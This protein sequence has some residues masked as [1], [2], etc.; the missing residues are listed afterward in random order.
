MC[1]QRAEALRSAKRARLGAHGELGGGGMEG[2]DAEEGEE[3]PDEA[4][5][6][7]TTVPVRPDVRT[8]HPYMYFPCVCLEGHLCMHMQRLNRSHHLP[9]RGIT[10]RTVILKCGG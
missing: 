10:W 1:L 8:Y 7:F 3:E 2:E 4:P 6:T 5:A 9:C